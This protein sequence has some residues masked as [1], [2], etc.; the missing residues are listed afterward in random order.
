MSM[1]QVAKG[2]LIAWG[3]TRSAFSAFMIVARNK[4]MSRGSFL[5]RYR[6]YIIDRE[7]P[8]IIAFV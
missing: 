4:R 6:A 2:Y 5:R 7:I 3:R 1:E 8:M